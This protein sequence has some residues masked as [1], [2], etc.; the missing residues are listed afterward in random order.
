MKLP[1]NSLRLLFEITSLYFLVTIKEPTMNSTKLRIKI[2]T[3]N[4]GDNKKK[5]DDW[6]DEIKKSWSIITAKDY[7]VLG[8]SLQEDW[9]GTYGKMGEAVGQ[10]LD[11]EFTMVSHAVEGPPDLT[12]LSFSVRA[13][14][15]F[16]KS[17]F[18]T[19]QVRK[20]DVCLKRT[21]F[22]SKGTAGLSIIAPAPNNQILQIILMSS[23]LPIDTKKVDLGYE[24]RIKAVAQTFQEVYDNIVDETVQQRV[25]FWA[26]DL[27][28]RADTPTRPGGNPT[29]DQLDYAVSVRPA[30][31]FREFIEPAVEFPPTCKMKSCDKLGCPACRNRSGSTYMHTCY[32]DETK[33]G[34]REPSHCDRILYRSDGV[35]GEIVEYK[36]WGSGGSVVV[37]DHNVVLSTFEITL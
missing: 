23:H 34:H 11:G 13:F 17:I 2:L 20:N 19:H 16:R 26:G 27:N 3:W 31:F 29:P 4:M 28:F 12:K 24:E 5:Q 9:K 21:V 8:L 25:A 6:L 33:S 15:Y 32:V 7:D 18:P 35:D 1:I 22:C 37:S 30:S 36:S 10:Y 14:L